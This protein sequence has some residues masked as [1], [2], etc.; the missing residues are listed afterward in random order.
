MYLHLRL[1]CSCLIFSSSISWELPSSQ[2][3]LT[4]LLI[5]LYRLLKQHLLVRPICQLGAFAFDIIDS[6][7]KFDMG[8]LG[9]HCDR[10]CMLHVCTCGDMSIYCTFTRQSWSTYRTWALVQGKIVYTVAMGHTSIS[11]L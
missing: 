9:S 11:T 3:I 10:M 7:T 4:T 6:C 5:S 2:I 8:D 1:C